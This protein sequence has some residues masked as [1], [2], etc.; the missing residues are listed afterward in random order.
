MPGILQEMCSDIILTT[1]QLARAI[2]ITSSHESVEIE[3]PSYKAGKNGQ[4]NSQEKKTHGYSYVLCKAS[5]KST[6]YKLTVCV[7]SYTLCCSHVYCLQARTVDGKEKRDKDF[8][9]VED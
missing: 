7:N 6:S 5:E 9:A 8:R 1:D 2:L 4:L 3:L